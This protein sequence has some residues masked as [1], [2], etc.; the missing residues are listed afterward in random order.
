MGFEKNFQARIPSKQR[1]KVRFYFTLMAENTQKLVINPWFVTGFADAESCF[2]VSI[3]SNNKMKAG[4]HVRQSFEIELHQKDKTLLEQI[5]TYLGVG[6]IFHKPERGMIQFTVNT[7]KDLLE[8][9]NHFENYPLIT[10]KLADYILFKQAFE[11][12]QR[13]EHLT[14]EG[15]RKL[16]SIKASLNW[17]LSSALQE[18]FPKVTSVER[19]SVKDKI[20]QDPHWLA[21]F[22]SG[23]GS[24]MVK[25]IPSKTITT[26]FQVLL[27]FQITQHNRDEEL[28]RS[29]VKYLNC[30]KVY[31]PSNS[32]VMLQVAKLSDID[33]ILI[34]FFYKYPILTPLW[35]PNL[36]L[37][38]R[39]GVGEKSNN[40]KD[41][42]RVAKLMKCGAHL[43]FSP[44]PP[45]SSLTPPSD[46]PI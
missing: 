2:T 29:L 42:C 25:V 8:I 13:K 16:V 39:R 35:L 21:G 37:G 22:T 4:W 23:E 7:Q 6:K 38:S 12:I 26:G 20:I 14:P 31:I 36:R 10:K 9:I 46:S 45:N 11:L 1:N 43:T 32:A 34:P 17:G 30:G 5:K 33:Q 15:L 41:F 19:F 3:V 40:F 18:A 24:F 28:L 44:D 27:V